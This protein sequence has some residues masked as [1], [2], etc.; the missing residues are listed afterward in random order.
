MVAG[1]V[2]VHDSVVAIIE[3]VVQAHRQLLQG[4]SVLN[5][6]DAENVRP[7][8]AVHL[9]DDGGQL[10]NFGVEERLCPSVEV[11]RQLLGNPRLAAGESLRAKRFSRF[12]K[13][14]KWLG[15]ASLRL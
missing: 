13:A 6:R 5:L 8:G 4:E 7:E 2:S 10:I 14:T 1:R 3:L 15:M 11:T 9:P 12:Q